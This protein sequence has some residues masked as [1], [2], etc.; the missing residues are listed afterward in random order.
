MQMMYY[1]GGGLSVKDKI[2]SLES[3]INN[4]TNLG[5]LKYYNYGI[6]SGVSN[7]YDAMKKV[8]LALPSDGYY[9]VYFSFNGACNAIMHRY[10]NSRYGMALVIQYYHNQAF[11][12]NVRDAQA[13]T[14]NYVFTDLRDDVWE[15]VGTL[16]TSNSVAINLYKEILIIPYCNGVIPY[17]S[18]IYPN[19]LLTGE[20]YISVYQ[21]NSYNYYGRIYNN[22]NTL[23][24]EQKGI[25][26]WTSMSLKIMGKRKSP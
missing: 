3:L 20:F 10:G 14:N 12:M 1:M 13:A 26:G 5:D 2:D 19:N 18:Y 25:T 21:N 24:L 15:N 16:T 7:I 6:T 8:W 9:L 11:L 22:A 4:K 23:T 17:N